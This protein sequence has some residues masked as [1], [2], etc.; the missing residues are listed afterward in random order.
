MAPPLFF[1]R[2]NMKTKAKTTTIYARNVKSVNHTWL[3]KEAKK[4]NIPMTTLID[5]ILD[6][7]R[8]NR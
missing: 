3:K 1:K 4:N 5:K 2:C 8:K 6:S 7:A